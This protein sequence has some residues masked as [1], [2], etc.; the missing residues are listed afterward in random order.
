MSPAQR[1]PY[2]P[3]R[4]QRGNP[5]QAQ[6]V[7]PP[8]QRL[9]GSSIFPYSGDDFYP[10]GAAELGDMPRH[11]SS[12]SKLWSKTVGDGVVRPAAHFDAP[13]KH[14][15]EETYGRACCANDVDNATKARLDSLR[16][17]LKTW[18]VHRHPKPSR[19]DQI[20]TSLGML[21]FGPKENA[22][23]GSG[24]DASGRV[25]LLLY[26]ELSPLELVF[27]LQPILAVQPGDVI[28]MDLQLEQ[29]ANHVQIT[30]SQ[31]GY[32]N[33]QIGPELSG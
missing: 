7:P 17:S 9:T 5:E 3:A 13:V 18:A 14:L 11:V 21:Y 20:W 6:A 4:G 31:W 1:M 32:M 2:Y 24:D 16:R 19:F 33:I 26:P 23:G 15:C 27:C 8:R 22:A 29:M 25:G 30:R 10:I 28:K 12:L